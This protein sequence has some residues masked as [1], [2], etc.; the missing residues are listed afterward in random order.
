MEDVFLELHRSGEPILVRLRMIE[1]I[2]P[3]TYDG[4]VGSLL[5]LD[6][7]RSLDVDEPPRVIAALV[8][9]ASRS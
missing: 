4:K 2:E 1:T 6:D 7:C 5:G 8:R 9:E 3:R